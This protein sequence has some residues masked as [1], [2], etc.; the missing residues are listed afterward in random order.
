MDR[1]A[2]RHQLGQLAEVLGIEEQQL[3]DYNSLAP[4]PGGEGYWLAIW[5]APEEKG[6]IEKAIP[7]TWKGERHASVARRHL[8]PKRK[9]VD[10]TRLAAARKMAG[11]T[12]PTQPP[13]PPPNTQPKHSGLLSVLN[14][15]S[16]SSNVPTDVGNPPS[17][18]VAKQVNTNPFASVWEIAI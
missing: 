4:N 6:P 9:R 14:G 17:Q 5:P 2:A 12:A 3:R 1:G 8:S 16:T 15:L 11:T 7:K 13:S 18:K 10:K